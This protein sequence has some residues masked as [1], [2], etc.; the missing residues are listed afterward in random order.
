[1][2][3]EKLL[4]GLFDKKILAIIRYFIKNPTQKFYLRELAKATRVPIASTYRI[5]N[6]LAGLEL[7]EI[8]KFKPFKLYSWSDS[9]QAK[10]IQYI[11]EQKKTVLD[12]FV[13]KTSQIQGVQ[14]IMLHGEATKTQ[15]SI[16]IIG[17][18]VDDARVREL[19]VRAKEE[20]NFNITYLSL[21]PSQ[22]NQMAS[23]GLYPKKKTILFEK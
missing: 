21:Q 17:D 3:S 13:E 1:M 9:E 10:Y 8:H 12:S 20:N 2:E 11:L 7:L 6:R 18:N 19:V 23:M 4:E 16:L 22:F 14:L 5:I 15:A